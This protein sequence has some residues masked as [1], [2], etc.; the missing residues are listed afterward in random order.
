MNS[1]ITDVKYFTFSIMLYRLK[2]LHSE[3]PLTLPDVASRLKWRG[4]SKP[5]DEIPA[6]VSMLD[7][8]ASKLI[9]LPAQE[10]MAGLLQAV[11]H[12][13]S[14]IIFLQGPKLETKGFKW[15]PS[16]FMLTAVG[17]HAGGDMANL[18]T[19]ALCTAE[20]LFADYMV[21]EFGT[22]TFQKS[23][24]WSFKD[25]ETGWSYE[26]AAEDRTDGGVYVC[27]AILRNSGHLSEPINR[28]IAVV[29]EVVS[30]ITE[31]DILKCDVGIA[32]N[33]LGHLPDTEREYEN[34][35]KLQASDIKRVW[36]R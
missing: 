32:L 33:L 35:R 21:Y 16:T 5:R 11:G 6:I 23:E 15:A 28:C 30:H 26:V 18:D 27:N 31:G 1:M 22:A 19:R 34:E 4:T 8:D 24:V 9:D 36:L 3:G 20:G 13:P 14:E 7:V 29:A 12:I 2:V 17:M 25:D 10:R